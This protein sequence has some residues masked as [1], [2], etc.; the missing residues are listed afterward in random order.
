MVYPLLQDMISFKAD[1]NGLKQVTPLPSTKP[2][3]P[4]QCDKRGPAE[5]G[6]IVG[7][8]CAVISSKEFS[9]PSV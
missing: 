4:P 1:T 9:D 8:S 3:Q 6:K 2:P 5:L 7:P